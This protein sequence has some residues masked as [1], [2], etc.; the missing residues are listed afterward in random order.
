M[1]HLHILNGDAI[2]QGFLQ[3][4][5]PVT[6]V[7]IWREVLAEGPV[8]NDLGTAAFWKQ[9]SSFFQDQLAVSKAEY[10]EKTQ[11]EF[12]TIQQFADYDA[13]TL[14]F[15]YDWF[16]QINMIGLLAFFNQQ[17]GKRPPISLVCAGE[18][19]GYDRLVGLGEIDPK[20]YPHLW[21]QRLLLPQAALYTA[22]Q[23]WDAYLAGRPEELIPLAQAAYPHFPYLAPAT[24]AH[25]SLYPQPGNGL[26]R[27]QEEILTIIQQDPMSQRQVVGK[28]LREENYLGFGDL[29][30]EGYVAGLSPLLDTDG[31]TLQLNDYGKA[32]LAGK[33]DFQANGAPVYYYGGANT[34]TIRWAPTNHQIIRL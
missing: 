27:L 14:W 28:M 1:K 3:Q 11:K 33:A 7:A 21:E 24:E 13:V 12:N 8:T 5:L 18:V 29:Q 31:D 9:R 22:S 34:K 16:C 32:V 10:Q 25:L 20:L 15:E 23:F 2:A 19:T 30:Y 6:T 17:Q 26:S 4:P